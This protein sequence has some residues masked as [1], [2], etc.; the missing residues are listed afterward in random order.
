MLRL[1]IDKI[2]FTLWYVGVIALSLTF[3]INLVWICPVY[4]TGFRYA[5]T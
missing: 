1:Q 5:K 3:S 2:D 4:E